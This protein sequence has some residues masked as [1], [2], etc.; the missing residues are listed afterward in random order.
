[1]SSGSY[2]IWLIWSTYIHTCIHT[3]IHTCLHTW[4]H[5][6][7]HTYIHTYMICTFIHDM[8]IHACVC[9][10]I[11]YI[12]TYTRTYMH[13]FMHTYMRTYIYKYIHTYIH[14]YTHTC[15]H[16]L[17]SRMHC[18]YVIRGLVAAIKVATVD[19]DNAFINILFITCH[20]QYWSILN[21]SIICSR[22]SA[23]GC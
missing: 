20:Y 1:M 5:A 3:W 16:I 22:A 19:V 13:T 6:Y 17:H 2:Y 18:V 10:Y 8:Y 12:H 11:Q 9:A 4:I 15:K 21:I 23:P 7:I 14:K